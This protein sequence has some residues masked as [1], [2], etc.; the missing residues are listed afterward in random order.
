MVE[1][2]KIFWYDK[3][4]KKIVHKKSVGKVL[5]IHRDYINVLLNR[6]KIITI[7]KDKLSNLPQG[8]YRFVINKKRFNDTYFKKTIFPNDIV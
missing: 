1:I 5:S 4:I 7:V 3:D 8:P 6:N 2:V